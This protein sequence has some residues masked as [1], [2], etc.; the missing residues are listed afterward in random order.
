MTRALLLPSVVWLL[1]VAAPSSSCAPVAGPVDVE[2]LVPDGEGDF[3]LD[4]VTLESVTD[5][6]RGTGERFDIRAAVNINA[7][8]VLEELEQGQLG[9]RE[10]VA[11]GRSDNG[12]DMQP[13][14]A[15]DGARYVA[16]DFDSLQYLTVFHNFERAWSF[17]EALGDDSTATTDKSMVGFYG[18][19]SLADELPVPLQTSDNAAYVTFSDAW[20]TFRIFLAQDGVPFAMNAG[21]IAHELHHRVFFHNVFGGE[22]FGSW[23][24]WVTSDGMSR[25]GNLVKGLDEGLADLFAVGVTRDLAFMSPSL[26]GA[27]SSEAGFRD[28]EGELALSATYDGLSSSLL[29]EEVHQHCGFARD[30]GQD[31]YELPQFNFYCAGTLVARAL[32]E[33]ASEDF[34]VLERDVLPAVNRALSGVGQRIADATS[35]DELLFD[36]DMF[37]DALVLELPVERQGPMCAAL[38]PRFESFFAEGR[39]PSCL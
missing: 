33:G 26:A 32:W 20:M 18:S 1:A 19:L 7:F 39:V 24:T 31:L 38:A 15:W 37:L 23:R 13:R 28:L 16:E 14:L 29:S 11:R 17:A 21:V 5:L 2:V 6:F 22:A 8:T 9:F 12:D 3:H 30:L 10:L 4:T 34:G 25:S 27:F 35:T 36:L